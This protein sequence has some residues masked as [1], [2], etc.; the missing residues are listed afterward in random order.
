[1]GNCTCEISD[2]MEGNLG[3]RVLANA[4]SAIIDCVLPE[5]KTWKSRIIDFVYSIVW[6]D[7]IYY[8]SNLFLILFLI[9]LFMIIDYV[10][11]TIQ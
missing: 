1:M 2:W 8:V 9:R 5:I 11:F 3:N 4:I 6:I 10:A 7:S